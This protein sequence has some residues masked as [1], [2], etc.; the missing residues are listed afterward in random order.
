M[1][2]GNPPEFLELTPEMVEAKRESVFKE[3]MKEMAK[4]FDDIKK[5]LILPPHA[6]TILPAGKPS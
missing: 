1:L 4:L 6:V 5:A 2:A 3:R